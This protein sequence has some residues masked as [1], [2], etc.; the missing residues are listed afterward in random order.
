[1]CE[2]DRGAVDE[3]EEGGAAGLETPLFK[4]GIGEPLDRAGKVGV[5]GG[6]ARVAVSGPLGVEVGLGPQVVGAWGGPFG[7]AVSS[8]VL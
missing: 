7:S 8:S 5:E 1:M 3:V 2:Y 4:G 6:A